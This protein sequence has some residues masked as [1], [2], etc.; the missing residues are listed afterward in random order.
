MRGLAEAAR[1]VRDSIMALGN[2]NDV[3]H[4][5]AFERQISERGAKIFWNAATLSLKEFLGTYEVRGILF[6]DLHYS[7]LPGEWRLLPGLVA[8]WYVL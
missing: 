7:C 6:D 3:R 2:L 5:V 4:G 8:H 1:V